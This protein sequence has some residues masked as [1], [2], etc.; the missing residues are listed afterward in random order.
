MTPIKTLSCV[1]LMAAL[2]GCAS[3]QPSVAVNEPVGPDLAPAR[4]HTNNGQGQLVVYTALEVD[5]P[6]TSDF[7]THAGYEIDDTGGKLV[8][9]VDNR[10]GSFYQAPVSV[11]LPPGEYKVK[12][13]ATNHGIVTVPIIVKENKV[14]TLDLQGTHFSQHKPTGAG[15]W[16][17]LPSG[18]VIG[19]RTP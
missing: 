18:E 2:A 12:A 17:R 10:S 14:T 19:M 5:N 7:P 11:S 16:V 8:R 13:L 15:Q 6:T 4:I 3:Q 1:A 9:H